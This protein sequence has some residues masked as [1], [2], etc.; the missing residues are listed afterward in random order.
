MTVVIDGEVVDAPGTDMEA[1]EQRLMGLAGVSVEQREAEITATLEQSAQLLTLV[2]QATDP[3]RFAS[4]GKAAAEMA[5]QYAKRLDVSKDMVLDAQVQQRRWEKALWDAVEEGQRR[6]DIATR[7]SAA[8][9]SALEREALKRGEQG[10]ADSNSLPRISDFMTT[11]ERTSHHA[12]GR[13]GIA[14]MSTGVSDA[15][16]MEALSDARD[17]GNV[18]R[19]NVVRKIKE[20]KGTAPAAEPTRKGDPKRAKKQIDTLRRLV[21]SLEGTQIIL[22]DFARA[23][24]DPAITDEEA[25]EIIAGL[26]TFVRAIGRVKKSLNGN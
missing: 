16:F 13:Y 5:A 19:A 25:N 8:R 23:G 10:V 12:T 11:S 6:G 17:E 7:S 4:A 26:D 1:L 9:E 21:N 18:S 3:A 20:A 24:L 22:D 14:E 15:D 2:S